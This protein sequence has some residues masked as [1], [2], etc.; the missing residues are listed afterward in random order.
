MAHG[1][2]GLARVVAVG[3]W[4]VLEA[5]VQAHDGDGG[6]GQAREVA[7]LELTRFRGRLRT[8]ATKRSDVNPFNFIQRDL[9]AEAIVELGGAG[10]LVPGDQ[11]RDLEV[12]AVPQILGDPGPAEAVG[13]DLGR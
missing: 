9:L 7:R 5:P 2:V 10:G 12:A 4:Q 3:L 1:V 6:V 8:V 13:G 11:G